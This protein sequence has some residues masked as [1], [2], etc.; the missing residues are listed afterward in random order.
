MSARILIVED[1]PAIRLALSG[2]LRKQ[3]Y[4]VEQA[5]SGGDALQKIREGSFDLVLTDLALGDGVSGMDVLRASKGAHPEMPVVMITAHGSE[6]VA[7]EAMKAGAEDY[8]PKPFDNDE[9]RLVVTRA[10]ERTRLA[11]EHAL[12][13]ERVKREYGFESLI[14]AGPKMRAIFSQI[15]KVAETD[16]S[17]LVRGESGT[18]KELVAQAIHQ[19]SPRAQ[20]PFVAVNC[21]AISRELVESELFGHEKGAF[22]GANARRIG[23]FEAAEGGTIFLDEIGDMPLE[24]QGKVLRVLEE[25]SLERVG[26]NKSIQ[27]DVRVVAATHR[28]LE[29]DVLRGAYRQD[30]YYRLKVV[31]LLVPPLRERLEDLPALVDRF[32]ERIAARLGREKRVVSAEAMAR[33]AT[34]AWPGNV[35]ELRHAIEQAA[36]LAS[37]SEIDVD[38]LPIASRAGASSGSP[39]ARPSGSFSEA[40]R[41]A[42]DA[43]ER[44]FLSDALK[45]H[46]GNI[47]QTAEA[48]G[49]VRQSLQQK[50]KEL[51]LRGS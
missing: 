18:G 28:D 22:T 45:R 23:R 43:F 34:H 14:G 39:S 41:N 32:L 1:E 48:I 50:L 7:V 8:V 36:V 17:V 46:G 19:R 11:R 44:A 5:P 9:M 42:V 20:R 47:S 3:G 4:E 16:L 24:T 25:R 31:E 40:K 26:G 15:Q 33:L 49:M 27:V 6:K 2:L 21:A 51:G 30:L 35:R 10:L 12:L 29:A 37:G 13:L 38:D